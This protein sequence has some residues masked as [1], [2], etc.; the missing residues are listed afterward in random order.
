VMHNNCGYH[1][2]VMHLQ[3]MSNRR[4]RVASLGK[5]IG[6]IGTRIENPNIDYAKLAQSMGVWSAGPITD[7]NDL[8]ATLKR[9]VEAVQAGQPAL[10]DVIT[11]PR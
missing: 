1:Q 10:V 7:P 8:A 2:E 4:N 3:R 5:D 9:A 11:Q 6:P